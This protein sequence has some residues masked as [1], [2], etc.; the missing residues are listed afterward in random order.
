MF[1]RGLGLV[2]AGAIFLVAGAAPA[3]GEVAVPPLKARVTDLTA[4]LDAQQIQ[5]LETQLRD[6]EGSKGSQVAVLMLPSTQPETAAQ[7]GVRVYDEWKLGRKGVD[8]GVL[9]LVAKDDRRV[10]IVTGRGVEGP[11]PD[12]AVKRIV[13]EDITPRFKQGDFY[14]GIRAGVDRIVRTIEG[15][16]LPPPRRAGQQ[17]PLFE[18]T[19][20]LIPAFIILMVAQGILNTIFGRAIG[21]GLTG[22]V[23]GLFAWII[24]GSLA[25]GAIVGVIAFVFGLFRGSP[26]GHGGGWNSGGGWSSGGGFSG[27]GGFGG[28]GGGFSGGGGSTAGGGAGGSW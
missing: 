14:G 17:S 10:W 7:Y 9:V 24:V 12:A 28:G 2:A 1:G 18:N 6:F 11:L 4:T 21:A 23:A 15:E 20:W 22:G 27:G 5:A 16:P 3:F 13:E 8:D 25:I 26:V 19:E